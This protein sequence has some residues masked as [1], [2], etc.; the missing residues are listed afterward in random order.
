MLGLCQL[1][2]LSLQL[3][4]VIRSLFLGDEPKRKNV[5]LM[6]SDDKKEGGDTKIDTD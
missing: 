5:A 6:D 3:L 1:N 2:H 4:P